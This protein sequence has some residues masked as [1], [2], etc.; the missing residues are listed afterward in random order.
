MS[1][2]NLTASKSRCRMCSEEVSTS[3]TPQYTNSSV[4][5]ASTLTTSIKGYIHIANNAR[6]SNQ[7]LSR[8]RVLWLRFSRW[9]EPGANFTGEFGTKAPPLFCSTGTQVNAYSIF[10]NSM[11]E[12]PESPEYQH[13]PLSSRTFCI[14]NRWKFSENIRRVICIQR[15]RPLGCQPPLRIV[16]ILL[17]RNVRADKTLRMYYILDTDNIL[18]L[19]LSTY[20]AR[21]NL[22]C[23]RCKES[24]RGVR[25]GKE[26]GK[27]REG[28]DNESMLQLAPRPQRTPWRGQ[29]RKDDSINDKLGKGDL[30]RMDRMR[31]VIYIP[32]MVCPE[33][34]CFS[35][36]CIYALHGLIICL[37]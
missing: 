19:S 5:W 34:W 3:H 22:E 29:Q 15:S 23:N 35:H 14:T 28:D 33:L 26:S 2:L 30:Q 8:F 27:E 6:K 21:R 36:S 7:T 17:P 9:L 32:T 1:I 20:C 10:H 25:C 31:N 18:L 11:E 16:H 13:L 37:R 12:V 24:R 4:R